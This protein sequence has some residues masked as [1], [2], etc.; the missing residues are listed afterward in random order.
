MSGVRRGESVLFGVLGG[1]TGVLA[2][3]LSVFFEVGLFGRE[4]QSVVEDS[5]DFVI[6]FEEI[7]LS[8]EVLR[9]EGYFGPFLIFSFPYLLQAFLDPKFAVLG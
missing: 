2:D 4:V 7:L 1:V 5:S 9:E 3:V 8:R 6:V